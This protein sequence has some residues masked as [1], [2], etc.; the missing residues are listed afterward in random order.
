MNINIANKSGFCMGVRN[1][2]HRIVSEINNS[3]GDIYIYGQL[4]HNPQTVKIL[5]KRGLKT[6]DTL[7]DIDNKTIAV[8]THGIPLENSKYIEKRSG[9]QINLTCPRVAKVQKIIEEYSSDGYFTLITGDKEH[10]EVTGLKSYAK[11][12]VYVISG[13]NDIRQIP[14]AKKYLLVSQTTFDKC[15]F[16]KI[17]EKLKNP[18]GNI[19]IFNTICSST[20]NIQ[21]EVNTEIKDKA[22]DTLIVIG[23]KNSANTRRLTQIGVNHNITSMHI[24]TENDIDGSSFS[25]NE[26]LLVAA[27]ASTPAWIVN[28]VLEKLYRIKFY[29]S[30]KA[31]NAIRAF[32]DVLVRMHIVSAAG[33][34]Y[35]SLFAQKY[36]GLPVSYTAA[37][38][39]SCVILALDTINNLRMIEFI[40]INNTARA[41]LLLKRKQYFITASFILLAVSFYLTLKVSISI[42]FCVVLLSLAYIFLNDSRKIKKHGISKYFLLLIPAVQSCIILA[43]LSN[44]AALLLPASAF[45]LLYVFN[46]LKIILTDIITIDGDTITGRVTLPVISGIKNIVKISFGIT[47]FCVLAFLIVSFAESAYLSSLYLISIIYFCLLLAPLSNLKF[48]IPLKWEFIVNLNYLIFILLYYIIKFGS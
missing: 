41:S 38:I 45:L 35:F 42:A 33:F 46:F 1:A 48:L 36:L 3:S 10:A 22:I 30:G 28:N 27:G 14:K 5:E 25:G 17:K 16:D 39:A 40:K 23:G 26:N 7:K 32:F 9:R 13:I 15:L 21:E 37:I 43:V 11:S 44:Y 6:I 20:Q 2:V 29:K 18:P 31:L 19:K 8:R 12:G 47:A 4:I 24:E 34:F